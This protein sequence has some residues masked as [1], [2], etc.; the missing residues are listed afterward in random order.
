MRYDRKKVTSDAPKAGRG[1]KT[2]NSM[3]FTVETIFPALSDLCPPLAPSQ[4]PPVE[5]Q[6]RRL[7]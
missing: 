2:I 6:P 1:D 7:P 4:P 5:A 3:P